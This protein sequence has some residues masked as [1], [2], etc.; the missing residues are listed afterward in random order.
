VESPAAPE[1][2]GPLRVAV[3]GVV[4]VVTVRP[5]SG[6][7]LIVGCAVCKRQAGGVLCVDGGSVTFAC[8]AGHTG[9]PRILDAV[10]VR[11][12]VRNVE[13][14]EGGIAGDLS[15]AGVE[16]SED[17]DPWGGCFLR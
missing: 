17:Y 11:N 10:R 12:A 5:G 1:P 9:T 4:R 16:M 13:V 7:M 2:T 8:P 15:V 14:F 3:A 6:A